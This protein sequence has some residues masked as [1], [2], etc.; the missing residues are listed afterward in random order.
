MI[1]SKDKLLQQQ[2][3]EMV[4]DDDK[5]H[6][7]LQE[8]DTWKEGIDQKVKYLWFVNIDQKRETQNLFLPIT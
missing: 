5:D 8:K 6:M 7:Y 2:K 3:G 1:I 4:Q